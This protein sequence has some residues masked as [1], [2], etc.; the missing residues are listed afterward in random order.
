MNLLN[1]DRT[2]NRTIFSIFGIK[3]KHKNKNDLFLESVLK[4]WETEYNPIDF[5]NYLQ[6]LIQ[7]DISENNKQVFL[8]YI[9]TLIEN[10][11]EAKAEQ[12]LKNFIQQ[13]GHHDLY[14]FP[15][16]CAFAKNKDYADTRIKKTAKIFEIMEQNKNNKSLQILLKNK[17]IAIVGNSPNLIGKKLGKNIDSY[18]YVVRFNNFQTQSFE[19]DY[20][21]K[22]NI[23]ICCQANDIVNLPPTKIQ[24][25]NYILYSVD[26]WHTKLREK[27]Y[28][29]ICNNINLGI[30]ISYIGSEFKNEL[31]N[32]GIIYPSSGLQGIYHLMHIANIKR[33]NI[34]GFSFLDNNQNYYD[35]YFSKRNQLKKNKLVRN[36]HHHFADESALLN[37]IF[38]EKQ[39]G[40]S[41]D[42][43]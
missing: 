32:F 13:Y 42:S 23:W 14:E 7:S 8:V 9:S 28:N 1:I 43:K 12:F 38:S 35:H 10:K 19:Q 15:V 4:K 41:C 24:Q 18:D 31:K 39:H 37:N 5:E 6:Q 17:T 36:N 3:F 34:F 26:L 2:G 40:K 16:I 22:T 29:N 11:K 20:G 33:Q 30:P 27:C 21:T 25:L